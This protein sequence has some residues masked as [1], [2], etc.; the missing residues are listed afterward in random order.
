MINNS[1]PTSTV[2]GYQFS[3]HYDCVNAGY[4]IAQSTFRNLQDHEEYEKEIIERQKLVIKFE[5]KKIGE[6]V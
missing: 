2:S 6:K 1:C 3:S 4:A 5:C